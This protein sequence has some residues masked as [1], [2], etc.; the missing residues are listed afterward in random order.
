MNRPNVNQSETVLHEKSSYFEI[1]LL[2]KGNPKTILY[3]DYKNF[4]LNNFNITIKKA[5]DSMPGKKCYTTF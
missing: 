5:L 4:D 1:I 3:R 2:K